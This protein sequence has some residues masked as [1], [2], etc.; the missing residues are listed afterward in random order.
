MDAEL[1]WQIAY[2]LLIAVVLLGFILG[3]VAF[4]KAREHS[5]VFGDGNGWIHLL[6]AFLA[7][8]LELIF[9][10]VELSEHKVKQ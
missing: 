2:G 4:I 1:T 10:S 6:L 5:Y 7:A 9:A 8:P 3:I